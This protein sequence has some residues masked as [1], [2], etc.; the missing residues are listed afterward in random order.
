[1]KTGRVIFS[2]AALGAAAIL[3]FYWHQHRVG[4][5]PVFNSGANWNSNASAA[6]PPT[7]EL[8]VAEVPLPA[9]PTNWPTNWATSPPAPRP[10]LRL[11]ASKMTS[12][13]RAVFEKAFPEKIK[14]AMERFAKVYAGRLPFDVKHVKPDKL[15][16]CILPDQDEGRA[17]VF[18]INGTTFGV[19]YNHGSV[20][21]NLLMAPG[22]QPLFQLSGGSK[23]PMEPSVSRDE[24]LNLLK[25][26]SGNVFPPDQIAIR[27]APAGSPMN[28][29]VSV[30]VGK[31]VNDANMAFDDI[32][33]S[34]VFD[35][36]GMLCCYARG[37]DYSHDK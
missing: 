18:V 12:A 31:G 21:V 19:T 3:F 33:Y 29:G 11:P 6:V 14:P 34:M 35:P 16:D 22:A 23:T 10:R 37:L 28:G 7:D 25:A 4:T 30:D 26:D 1:M 5:Q 36:K 2:A 27:P 24:I 17:Y 20:F 13:D 32:K 8:S 9:V 15:A